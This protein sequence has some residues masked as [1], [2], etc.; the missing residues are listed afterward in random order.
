MTYETR[1]PYF[2][3][4]SQSHAK[5]GGMGFFIYSFGGEEVQ[6]LVMLPGGPGKESLFSLR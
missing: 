4:N 1:V 3:M 6:I 5:I 2:P